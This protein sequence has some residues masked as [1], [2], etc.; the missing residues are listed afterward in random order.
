[1][2]RKIRKSGSSVSADISFRI[3]AYF[4]LSFVAVFLIGLLWF[5]NFG[6]DFTDESYYFVWIHNPYLYSVSVSQF[7]FIYHPL[8]L[9]FDG[10]FVTLRKINILSIY[11]FAFLLFYLCINRPNLGISLSFLQKVILSLCFACSSLVIFD[12]WLL[13]TPNYNSLVLLALIIVSIGVMLLDMKNPW[14]YKFGWILIGVGGWLTFMGKPTSAIALG[15]MFLGYLIV[16]KKLDVRMIIAALFVAIILFVISAYLIDGGVFSFIHRLLEG[17]SFASYLGG[18]HTITDSFRIDS[19]Q[20]NFYG[21]C[22]IIFASITTFFLILVQHKKGKS[23][24]VYIVLFEIILVMVITG[25]VFMEVDL[26][27]NLSG[28]QRNTLLSIPL[29][30]FLACIYFNSYCD[31]WKYKDAKPE[32]SNFFICN[33]IYICIWFWSKLLAGIKF[34]RCFLGIIRNHNIIIFAKENYLF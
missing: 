19:L 15:V 11:S 3:L 4:S 12:T 24:N 6:L 30:A 34:R 8:Y 28:F 33:A 22:I 9:L 17:A 10:N 20:L 14:M 23:I 5:C 16:S 18:K 25:L 27:P 29:I 1:M 2:G 32:L 13:V 31:L 21:V 26:N 7:G